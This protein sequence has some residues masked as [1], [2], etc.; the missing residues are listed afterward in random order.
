MGHQIAICLLPG[1]NE[2]QSYGSSVCR[3]HRPEYGWDFD[4]NQPGL[5]RPGDED[6]DDI[7]E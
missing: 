1:C 4:D 2:P 6:S 7:S 5:L 3:E